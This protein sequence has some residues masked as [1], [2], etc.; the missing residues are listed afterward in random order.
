MIK[1]NTETLRYI[2]AL[3]NAS[4]TE[5]KDCI[6]NEDTVIYV[7][8][9][10]QLGKAVGKNGVRV[11]TIGAALGKKVRVVEFSDDPVKFVGN[12]LSTL[13]VKNIFLEEVTSKETSEP[14][15]CIVIEADFKTRG[16][17]LGKGGKKVQL[18]RDLLKRHHNI[19]DVVVK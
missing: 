15:K 6:V 7:V 2:A 17:I 18:L 11:K 19:E 9:Q 1:L 10:G 12:M 16:S 5:V 8:N 13:T 4:G 14:K 3:E